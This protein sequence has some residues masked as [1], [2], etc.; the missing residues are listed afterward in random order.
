MYRA[1]WNCCGVLKSSPPFASSTPV[2][3][4]YENCCAPL[5]NILIIACS[6]TSIYLRPTIENRICA[7]P[8][9]HHI[10]RIQQP[11]QNGECIQIRESSWNNNKTLI[12]AF[13]F[14]SSYIYITLCNSLPTST[15]KYPT[16]SYVQFILFICLFSIA[17][18]ILLLVSH[19]QRHRMFCLI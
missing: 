6:F 14:D 8:N 19:V 10:E 5:I 18:K 3:T 11:K 9:T 4:C 12:S 2:K 15:T 13:F 1:L 17:T 7:P 16:L